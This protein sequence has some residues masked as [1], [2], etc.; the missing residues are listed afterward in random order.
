LNG[1]KIYQVHIIALTE[2]NG[3]VILSR[4]VF[5]MCSNRI[6][7]ETL[8]IPTDFHRCPQSLQENAKAVTKHFNLSI[9]S[10]LYCD[11]ASCIVSLTC[12]YSL[13]IISRLTCN[14]L[15]KI[16]KFLTYICSTSL[17]HAHRMF[18]PTLV[19]FRCLYNC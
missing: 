11:V 16:I 5:G 19:I 6:L 12:I 13:L 2:Q 8:S 14:M 9:T 17:V 4:I 10:P 15:F 3:I 1:K 18:R 7:P